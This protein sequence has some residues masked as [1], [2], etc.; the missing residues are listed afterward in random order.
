MYMHKAMGVKLSK[1][2]FPSEEFDEGENP[3]SHRCTSFAEA[4]I[5]I[6]NDPNVFG[7]IDFFRYFYNGFTEDSTIW[8]AYHDDNKEYENPV[9][10]HLDSWKNDE[11]ATNIMREIISPKILP[12]NFTSGK[13]TIGYEFYYTSVVAIQLGFV[14]VPPLPYFTDKVQA[15]NSI[16]NAL[17]YNRL[18]NPEPDTD[19]PRLADWQVTPFT[20]IPFAQWWSE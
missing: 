17:A 18:K 1:M 6:A 4:A 5:M 10:F 19:M 13:S 8:F 9:K 7:K 15:R 11:E 14:Q 12:A 20:T 3:I 2:S 16:G